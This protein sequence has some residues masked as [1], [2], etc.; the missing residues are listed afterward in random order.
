MAGKPGVKLN[1]L[2]K[3]VFSLSVQ[4]LQLIKIKKLAYDEVLV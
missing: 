3:E 4:D 2:L 1:E